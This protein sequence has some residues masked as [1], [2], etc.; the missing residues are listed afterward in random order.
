MGAVCICSSWWGS[1][2]SLLSAP[3]HRAGVLCPSG[4]GGQWSHPGGQVKGEAQNVLKVLTCSQSTKAGPPDPS[5]SSCPECSDSSAWKDP[6]LSMF[7][8]ED[9]GKQNCLMVFM[10]TVTPTSLPGTWVQKSS[11]IQTISLQCMIS[12]GTTGLSLFPRKCP[13]PRVTHGLC[14]GNSDG[15]GCVPRYLGLELEKQR[16]A[17]VAA[18]RSHVSLSWPVS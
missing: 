7:E 1:G 10:V 4:G 14:N 6:K 15:T 12:V 9:L 5:L 11:L 8:G 16:R 2:G 13:C 17:W 3:R 18:W